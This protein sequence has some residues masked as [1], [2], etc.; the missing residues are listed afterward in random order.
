MAC[1]LARTHKPASNA[2]DW[3]AASLERIADVLEA[4]HG[5]PQVQ[6]DD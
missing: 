3:I 1:S 5:K 2:L 6:A 4:T